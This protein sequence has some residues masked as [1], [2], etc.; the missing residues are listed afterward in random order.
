LVPAALTEFDF[1]VKFYRYRLDCI[2]ERVQSCCLKPEEGKMSSVGGVNGVFVTVDNRGN[3][4]YVDNNQR[5]AMGSIQ[6]KPPVS[7][8]CSLGAGVE[9][10]V[11]IDNEGNTWRGQPRP[12]G[13]FTKIG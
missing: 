3:I 10:C 12:P 2:F 6:A 7:V 11:I 13:N 8:A 1:A 9:V 4:H 5:V